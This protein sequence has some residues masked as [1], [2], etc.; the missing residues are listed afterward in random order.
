[1]SNRIASGA[2]TTAA[3]LFLAFGLTAGCSPK[4]ATPAAAADSSKAK[5][6]KVTD[7]QRARLQI[8]TLATANFRPTLEV[9]GTVAFNGDKST[10]VLSAI[11]GPVTRL[12]ANLGTEVSPG[13]ALAMVASPDFAAAVATYRK[14]EAALRNSARILK[15]DEQLF[16]NDAIA[17]S[18]LEQARTDNASA[19]A[20]REAAMLALY[21]LG[22]DATTVAAI[23]DGQQAAPVESAIRSPI[24]GTV[25]E[26]MIN[27]GQQLQAGTTPTFT[28]ADLATMWVIASVYTSDISLVTA[29]VPV[30]ILTDV[31]PKPVSGRVDYVG[32]IVDPGTKATTVRIVADNPAQLLKR[33]MFV[34]ML[35]HS[36]TDRAGLLVPV[37]AVLRDDENLPFVF[38]AGA[39]GTFARRRVTVGYR[40]TDRYE[41]TAG[42]AVGEKVVADGALFLQFAQSQ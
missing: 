18:D 36:R 28:V 11:S 34:R 16:A 21:A 5:A 23:R 41:V 24:R 2:V 20:D 10:Q 13:E 38:I 6:F 33:D 15:Q 40:V 14:S 25:V 42:L 32:A 8:V 31:S 35:V 3:L 22:L 37:A 4:P 27:P 9:T 30:D 39:D 19:T 26:R 29:G 7:A 12:I 1:M 17:R